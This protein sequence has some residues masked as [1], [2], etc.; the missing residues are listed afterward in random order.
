MLDR[1]KALIAYIERRLL[2]RSFWSDVI[3]GV[4]AAAALPAPWSYWVAGAAFLKS[5]VPDAVK[6]AA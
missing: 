2:E 6:P 1:L 5:L 3:A 4:I